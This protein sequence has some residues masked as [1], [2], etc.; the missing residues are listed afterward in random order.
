MKSKR[1]NTG[2][3]L[4]RPLAAI[5]VLAG[6]SLVTETAM[7]DPKIYWTDRDNATLSVHDVASGVTQELVPN[8]SGRLQDVDLDE[9]TGILYFADWGPPGL[10]VLT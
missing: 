7:A 9:S 3:H 6:T 1:T 5:A 10:A 2:R 8:T 4:F